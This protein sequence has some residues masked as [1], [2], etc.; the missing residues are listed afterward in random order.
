M[1]R[2]A[3]RRARFFFRLIIAHF[4]ARR[5]SRLADRI[6]N[7]LLRLFL[8]LAAHTLKPYNRFGKLSQKAKIFVDNRF[9]KIHYK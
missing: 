5:S 2:L 4:A 3:L 7:R 8:F 6:E 1:L 9:R